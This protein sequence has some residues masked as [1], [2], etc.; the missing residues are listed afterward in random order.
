I[1]H[2]EF[3]RPL[4]QAVAV[5]ETQSQSQ[6]IGSSQNDQSESKEIKKEDSSSSTNSLPPLL[7][8][9]FSSINDTL[10][11][12]FSKEPPHT[13]QRLAELLLFPR[14]NYRSL[15]SFLLALDRVVH[16]TSTFTAFPLPL[17][18]PDLSAKTD[19]SDEKNT[20]GVDSKPVSGGY[21]VPK[22]PLIHSIG[23][24]EAFGGALLTPIP[25]LIKSRSSSPVESEVVTQRSTEIIEGPN[26]PGGVETV[27]VSINGLI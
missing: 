14:L 22:N 23:S 19:S 3:P 27:S 21:T 1:V 18:S 2:H 17:M 10:L 9:L 7:Q 11:K 4:K 25:W 24:D 26:G 13:I 20:D 5:L 15:S 12:Y 6:A 16:V 8:T